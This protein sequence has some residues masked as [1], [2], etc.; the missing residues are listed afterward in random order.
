MRKFA[1]VIILFF[2]NTH[3]ISA[4]KI[5]SEIN[6]L[7]NKY[8]YQYNIL[9]QKIIELQDY[10][11]Q[12]RPRQHYPLTLDR[13]QSQQH[14]RQLLNNTLIQQIDPIVLEYA[15][16]VC[17]FE[18]INLYLDHGLSLQCYTQEGRGNML[19]FLIHC[20]IQ[21][22]AKRNQVLER[23][24]QVGANP[25]EGKKD[26]ERDAAGIYPIADATKSCDTSM[27]D[28][29]LKYGANPNLKTQGEEYFPI[30]N[31]CSTN[32]NYSGLGLPPDLEYP[33]TPTLPLA[34]ILQSL[35]EYGADPNTIYI[36][37]DQRNYATQNREQ[38]LKIACA[39]KDEKAKSVYDLYAHE[40]EEAKTEGDPVK[41]SNFQKLFD[42]L[43]KYEAKPLVDLCA[44]LE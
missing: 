9:T 18:N 34:H 11:N 35:L 27:L 43:V 2:S 40:F 36:T 44:T 8:P 30:L 15:I 4:N 17:D 21:G 5:C 32:R 23:L 24:L 1:F 25:N 28:I 10:D 38:I 13:K 14:L 16:G 31:I 41:I 22:E 7:T 19:G 42:V 20:R 29:L 33:P 6:Q 12:Q 37:E 39:G 3:S 26:L